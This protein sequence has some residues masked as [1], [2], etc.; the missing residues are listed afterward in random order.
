MDHRSKGWLVEALIAA[1]PATVAVTGGFPGLF[2][3][4]VRSYSDAPEASTVTALLL[5]ASLWTLVEF[6]RIAL[7]TVARKAYAFDGRFWM[8]VAGLLAAGVHFLPTMP[9]G[10]ALILV[11]LPALAWIHFIL[12]QMK[13]PKD[14]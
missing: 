11:V 3:N 2:Y 6:W 1:G 7:A 4:L 12:L 13:R 14:A 9:A 5:A 10:L 8:A